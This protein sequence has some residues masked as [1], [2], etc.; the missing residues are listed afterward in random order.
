M[1]SGPLK[2]FGFL[3]SGRTGWRSDREGDRETSNSEKRD[4]WV[5]GGGGGGVNTAERPERHR[6]WEDG[7]PP[8]AGYYSNNR[9]RGGHNPNRRG[10]DESDSLPE[11]SVDFLLLVL[12]VRHLMKL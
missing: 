7:R 3:F 10:W 5:E 9:G 8:G 2:K 11:W 12:E 4:P 1:Y 6:D